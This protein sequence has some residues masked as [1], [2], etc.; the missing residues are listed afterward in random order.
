MDL[1]VLSVVSIFQENPLRNP[2]IAII[3]GGISG[4]A[5]A[6]HLLEHGY[7]NVT[8]YEARHE[9]GG[10]TRSY[11]DST[12]GD[13]LDNGQHLMMGCYHA[14]LEYLRAIGSSNLVHR[15]PLAIAFHEPG[16]SPARFE[17]HRRLAPSI[18]LLAGLWSSNLLSRS[19]K[20]AAIR[21][22]LAI[23]NNRVN[24]SGSC[25]EFF[26][27]RKQ[28]SKLIRKLWAPIV[29]AAINS[30]LELASAEVFVNI[31]REIFLTGHEGSDLLFP[32]VGLS[33]LLI[34]PAI[35]MLQ[36]HGIC[37]RFSAPVREIKYEGD[38]LRVSGN[39]QVEVYDSVIF[40]GQSDDPLPESISS[41]LPRVEYSPIVNA[42]FWL[43][44]M[45][46]NS[47]IHAFLGTTLQWA[48]PKPTAYASHRLALTVSAASE[49]TALTN[50]KIRDMLWSDLQSAVSAA[51]TAKLLHFQI[52]REKRAT[53]MLTPQVQQH[54]PGAST[55]I[56]GL[57]LAGDIVQ[58]GL[59][60]T[61]E[62]AIRNGVAAA[63]LVLRS[64]R[65][66]EMREIER[67]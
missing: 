67:H 16:K 58:N 23:K 63:R 14:T 56:P 4:L 65:A 36:A 15:T 48:F 28:P 6:V 3:G 61:I 10:R 60:A 17:I 11:L 35:R 51:R 27:A 64:T 47:P 38:S 66:V 62:G 20:I 57:F 37:V 25:K 19:E 41:N 39:N 50:E 18:N 46:L 43:D 40:C 7:R 59:S 42:Y 44:R 1:G 26:E 52:I 31:F 30:P 24:A 9:A 33:E 5:A 45:V 55:S 2:K 34:D 22:G 12:T 21:L 53:P 32:S 54:R 29:L 49:L 8:L 13:I